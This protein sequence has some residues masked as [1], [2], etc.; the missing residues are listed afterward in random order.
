[1]QKWSQLTA[2]MTCMAWNYWRACK[3]ERSKRNTEQKFTKYE[4][5]YVCRN[6]AGLSFESNKVAYRIHIRL[7]WVNPLERESRDKPTGLVMT[8]RLLRTADSLP[9]FI[10]WSHMSA[11][12]NLPAAD[13][14][15][16]VTLIITVCFSF[17]VNRFSQSFFFLSSFFLHEQRLVSFSQLYVDS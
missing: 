11:A 16:H 7:C 13:E 14:Q 10:S 17:W 12:L 4:Y 3:T 2:G 9:S 6:K 5:V 1:M 15:S 8:E